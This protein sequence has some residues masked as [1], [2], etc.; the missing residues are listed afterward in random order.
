MARGRRAAAPAP[1]PMNVTMT[2]AQL[3]AL[4]AQAVTAAVT[5]VGAQQNPLNQNNIG[6]TPVPRGSHKEFMDGKPLTFEG[7]EGPIGLIRWYEKAEAVFAVKNCVN[8]DRVKF[9]ASTFLGD[10]LSWWNTHVTTVGRDVADATPW[11]EFKRMLTDEYCSRSEIREMEI[12]FWNL[13]VKGADLNSFVTRF[14]ELSKL[15]PAMVTPEHK[16]VELF[17]AGLPDDMQE[18]VTSAGKETV[19]EVILLAQDLMRKR[20]RR[21]VWSKVVETRPVEPKS[22]W[23]SG[24]V[25]HYPNK[26][27]D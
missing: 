20:L 8:Q 13:K 3:T 22:R 23:D 6:V 5:A 7:T 17:I 21:G 27:L 14:R 2:N 9:A 19:S 12:E 15:C 11:E 25:N 26:R 4:V 10:A 1:P 24:P 16:G 18:V